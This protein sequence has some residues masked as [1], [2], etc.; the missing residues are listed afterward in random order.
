MKLITS[1]CVYFFTTSLSA[2]V[3]DRLSFNVGGGLAEPV[4]NTAKNINY[5]TNL[6][7]GVGVNFSPRLGA[8]IETEYDSFTI[9]RSA[10]STLGVPNGFPGGKVHVRSFALQPIWH[11]HPNGIWD[12]YAT[13]GAGFYERTQQLTASSVANATGSNPFFGFNT[14]GSPASEVALSYTVVKPGVDIGAGISLKVKWRLKLYAEVKYNHAFMG[15][16]GH[17]NYLP[18]S[19]GVRW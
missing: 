7:G 11:F 19:M 10:L 13:G 14:P 16:L 5:G 15:S 17:M 6:Q 12:V 3:L 18:V 1:L 2:Q 8:M 4:L 9:T